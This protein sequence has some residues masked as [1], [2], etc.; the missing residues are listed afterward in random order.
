MGKKKGKTTK[1]SPKPANN[2]KRLTL[3]SEET[4]FSGESTYEHEYETIKFCEVECAPCYPT[5]LHGTR[6]KNLLKN[7][8]SKV[9]YKDIIFCIPSFFSLSEC[10]AWI[11]YSEDTGFER[12]FHTATRDYA[13]RDNGRISF[14][15]PD[16][17]SVIWDRISP[18]IPNDEAVGTPVGCND[19][20]RLY[21]YEAGQRFG[22]HVDES[23]EDESGRRSEYTVLIYLS[24]GAESSY[25][26][27]GGETVFYKGNYGNKVAASFAPKVG[28]ALVHGHGQRCLLHEGALVHSGIKYL[29]RTDVMV[30]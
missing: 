16:L 29:M 17:A 2:K 9:V 25:P 21:K 3:T 6:K 4:K 1:S 7:I 20:I 11:Q 28:Y 12:S 23:V 19:N 18:F 27:E 13:H 30:T 22:R 5:V 26:V 14:S 8:S 15:S 10:D 24:G